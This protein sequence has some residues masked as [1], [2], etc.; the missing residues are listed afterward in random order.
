MSD[1]ELLVNA[2]LA[3]KYLWPDRMHKQLVSSIKL[4]LEDI[5]NLICLL[6]E[7]RLV[8][9]YKFTRSDLLLQSAAEDNYRRILEEWEGARSADRPEGERD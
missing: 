2:I 6:N 9:N 3:T 7:A 4:L 1:A 8:P 5:Q